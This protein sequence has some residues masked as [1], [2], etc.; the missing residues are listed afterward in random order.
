MSGVAVVPLITHAKRFAPVAAALALST[1]FAL[2]KL[3]RFQVTSD[4]AM[5]ACR[6]GEIDI[7]DHGVRCR[8]FLCEIGDRRLANTD[9]RDGAGDLLALCA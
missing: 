9:R 4:D 3:H 5:A 8:P 1:V 6:A 2:A 7:L